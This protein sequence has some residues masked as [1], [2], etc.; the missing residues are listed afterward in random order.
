MTRHY[1]PSHRRQAI[2]WA[3]NLLA[4]NF[5]V[6]DTETTGLGERDEIIQIGIVDAGG[7]TVLDQLIK[8]SIP[9]PPGAA[10]VHGITD[11]DVINSPIFSSL[12]IKLSSLLAGETVIAYNMDFDWRM[13]QQ[14]V[15]RYRLPDIR[16]GKR[17]CAMKQYAKFKGK[18]SGQG[19]GY[20]WHKLTSAL[21]Q[22]SIAVG[23]AHN[24]LGD[25][26]M[27]LELVRKMA[28]SS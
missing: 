13:L 3:Q 22:E 4:R 11:G 12:Y 15:A 21:A 14:T 25:A 7:N 18:R 17:D 1:N 26:L 23:D 5:Y 20:V 27:T 28:S 6:L 24:A 10:R 19:R 2:Q 9:I 16:I 8:P